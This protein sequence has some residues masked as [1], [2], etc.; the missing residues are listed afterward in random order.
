MA[1]IV[2][3]CSPLCLHNG[4]N[5][6]R[7]S[8]VIDLRDEN[9]HPMISTRVRMVVSAM[10]AMPMMVFTVRRNATAGKVNMRL[11]SL[12]VIRRAACVRMRDEHH[13]PSKVSQ[14]HDDRNSATH[15][16]INAPA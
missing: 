8:I 7:V 4:R 12:M 15:H 10:L 3:N 5:V 9:G 16:Y 2:L 13:L 14:K 6:N 1:N 11:Q